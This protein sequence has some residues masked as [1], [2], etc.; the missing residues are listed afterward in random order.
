MRNRKNFYVDH[1]HKVKRFKAIAKKRTR[2]KLFAV[3]IVWMEYKN[4][5]AVY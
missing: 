2:Q 5:A 4:I 1:E 3:R